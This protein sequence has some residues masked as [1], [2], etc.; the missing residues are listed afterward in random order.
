MPYN[1]GKSKSVKKRLYNKLHIFTHQQL[2]IYKTE[3]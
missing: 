3:I 1:L 2:N